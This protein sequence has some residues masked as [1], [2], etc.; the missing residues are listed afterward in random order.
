[1]YQVQCL[2]PGPDQILGANGSAGSEELVMVGPDSAK[3]P[4]QTKIIHQFS[5]LM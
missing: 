5:L 3:N 2:E 1:M 4:I